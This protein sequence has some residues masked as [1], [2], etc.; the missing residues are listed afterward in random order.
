MTKHPDYD[1]IV[2][3]A[4]CAGSATAMLLARS[5]YRVLLIDRATFPRDTLSTHIVWQSGVERLT[6]WGL[7]DAVAASGCPPVS[8]VV[9]DADPI[10]LAGRPRPYRQ[11]DHAFCVRRT[12]LDTILAESAAAAGAELR[13]GTTVS[14]LLWEGDTVSGVR[15][16]GAAV[17][18]R[19]IIGADGVHSLVA[20]SVHAA[21]YETTP[22]LTC[23][24]YSYFSGADVDTIRI[25]QRP[26][27]AVG[28]A[29]TNDGL[30]LAVAIAPIA[31]YPRIRADVEG[32]FTA[33]LNL[34]PEVARIVRAGRRE[35]RIRGTAD[36]PN[37]LRVPNGPGWA[38]VGDAGCHKDPYTAQGISDAFRDAEL[39]AEAVD[40]GLREERPMTAALTEH[41]RRRDEAILP[42]YALTTE[43][44]AMQPPS[45]EL[46]ALLS[47]LVGQPDA[48]S[49]FLG[50][51][52]GSASVTE[53]FAPENV[54]QIAVG[55]R[56]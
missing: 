22:P 35:D 36:L 26:G 10:V 14:D 51:L 52:A 54:D 9:F 48:I 7:A 24:Y 21:E 41:H 28:Y 47:G 34:V 53:F 49:Q 23:L 16:D 31:D 32:A 42:M 38:L 8:E 20:G 5:G 25:C 18:A 27:R 37:Y 6:R 43:M 17:T 19:I 56:G 12:V 15:V 45:D 46:A 1:V 44:A 39:L 2:I 50:V 13:L 29:P 30:T 3:G 40:A 4:R 55:A 33:S 11:V